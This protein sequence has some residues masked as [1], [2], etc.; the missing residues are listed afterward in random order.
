MSV[1]LS[2]DQYVDQI[3]KSVK[4]TVLSLIESGKLCADADDKLSAPEKKELQSRTGMLKGTFSGWVAIGRCKFLETHAAFLPPAR[5]TLQDLT[6]LTEEDVKAGIAEGVLHPDAPRRAVEA[7]I[8]AKRGKTTVAN[9]N[10]IIWKIVKPADYSAEEQ[11]TLEDDLN[12]VLERNRCRLGGSG[13]DDVAAKQKAR[14]GYIRTNSKAVI[15][16]E[17]LRCKQEPSSKP[18]AQRWPF[19]SDQVKITGDATAD[20]C[21]EVLKRIGCEDEWH[22]LLAE[23]DRLF[24]AQ[25]KPEQKPPKQAS[26]KKKAA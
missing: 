1:K 4:K 3:T 11:A 23:A 19:S 18:K 25:K 9:D 2:V 6:Q 20:D 5:T 13:S 16:A 22:R 10:Q 24:G 17:K 26:T 7:W 8:A 15:Q 14:A 21:K 12:K